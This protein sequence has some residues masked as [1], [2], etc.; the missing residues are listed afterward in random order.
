MNLLLNEADINTHLI[1]SE[2][3]IAQILY[4]EQIRIRGCM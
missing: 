1:V 2:S 3:I 4:N